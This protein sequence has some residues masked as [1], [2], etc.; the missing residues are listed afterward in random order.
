[1]CD[2]YDPK[3]EKCGERIPV[4]IGDFNYPREDVKVFC[5]D[6]MPTERVTVF[7]LTEDDAFSSLKAGWIC[8]I[9]LQDGKIEPDSV[10]VHPNTACAM[11]DRVFK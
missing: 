6:H 1:M 4:H 11:I 10:D 3:C 8:G 9:R 2:C 5:K 7:M